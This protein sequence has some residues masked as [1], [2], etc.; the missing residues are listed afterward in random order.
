M[1]V[2]LSRCLPMILVKRNAGMAVTTK[3]IMTRLSGWVR[4]LRSPR[5]PRGKRRQEFSDAVAEI[6]WQTKNGTELD[7]D[8]VHLPIAVGE[9]DMEQSFS[10]AQMR[11][12]TNRQ[13]FRKAFDNSEQQREQIGRSIIL[14][15]K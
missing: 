3:A 13:K 5:S 8:G 4:M 9:A 2:R 15:L 7:H 10:D 12:G 14:H 11:S 1:M 6:N